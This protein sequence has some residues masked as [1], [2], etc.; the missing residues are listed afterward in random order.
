MKKPIM[1][2][3]V[4]G[5]A[6]FGF[7]QKPPA[8]PVLQSLVDTERAFARTSEEK[9]IRPSFMEFIAED[10]ILFRP[11]PVKGKQW[12]IDHPLP[13]SDKHPLLSWQ[14]AFAE[15]ARSGD[16]GYTTGPWQ[17]KDDVH[18]ARPGAFGNFIT[19]WKKQADG[20]WKFAA[21]LG[22]SNL[23]PAQAVGQW[24][25][26]ANYR[27]PPKDARIVNFESERT[28]LLARERDFSNASAKAG[29]RQAF[30]SFAAENVR[31]FREEKFP[32][33]GRAAASE[34]F[35]TLPGAW[36]W[37]PAFADVSSSGDLGY[38][39][40]TYNL[41]GG[42]SKKV[43]EKGNYLRIWKKQRAVWQVVI[44]VATPLPPEPKPS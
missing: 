1:F 8:A 27:E 20:S 26:P 32:F 30:R 5:F 39:Y 9:G 42:D 3:V 24:Q 37:Q 17:Y 41:N 25:L 40:G 7:A 21:D 13:P 19:V 14:P 15:V 29:A 16:M 2:V 22:I 31:V 18:D 43:A 34:V 33:V 44:D 6:S 23:E 10:G 4:L 36:T 35:S 12:M 28:A 38:T 11:G